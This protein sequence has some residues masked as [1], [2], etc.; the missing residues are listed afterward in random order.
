MRFGALMF[1]VK[2]GM[3]WMK[4]ISYACQ[5]FPTDVIRQTAWL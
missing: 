1:W 3:Q 4:P 5:R 2:L